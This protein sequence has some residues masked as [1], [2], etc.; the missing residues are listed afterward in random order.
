M[1]PTRQAPA[2]EVEHLHRLHE[3]LASQGSK[4]DRLGT[5]CF[6]LCVYGRARWSDFRYVEKVEIQPGETVTFYTTEHK[7]AAVGLRRQQYLWFLG[8]AS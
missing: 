3:I 8:R 5:G 6:L 1:G 4:I 2:I 7:T